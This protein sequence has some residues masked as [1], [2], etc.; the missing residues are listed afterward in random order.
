[1][2][3]GRACM[4]CTTLRMYSLSC[5]CRDLR[6]IMLYRRC[7]VKSSWLYMLRKCS[8]SWTVASKNCPITLDQKFAVATSTIL[9]A[10]CIE[11]PQ[12]SGSG[13][14]ARKPI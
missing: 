5:G 7:L 8:I 13:R 1:M 14:F 4:L 6:T 9:Q 2:G 12:Q 3:S 11:R 10:E